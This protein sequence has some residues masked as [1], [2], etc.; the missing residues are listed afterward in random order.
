MRR[1]KWKGEEN[2]SLP[3]PADPVSHRRKP[4]LPGEEAPSSSRSLVCSALPD[5]RPH[6]VLI[7]E[8]TTLPATVCSAARNGGVFWPCRQHRHSP[9]ARQR[10]GKMGKTSLFREKQILFFFFSEM[11]MKRQTA[12]TIR[13]SHA[14]ECPT[15]RSPG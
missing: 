4:S 6:K 7:K 5:G 15:S 12:Q 11:G 13:F 8:I 3:S 14:H 1:E 10:P 2:R 9:T